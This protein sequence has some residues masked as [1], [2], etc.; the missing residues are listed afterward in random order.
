SVDAIAEFK[1]ITGI[2]P[3]EYGR[4]GGAIISVVTKSGSNQLHGNLFEFLRNN[5]FDA[6]NFFASNS[7]HLV[8]NQFGGSLG[9]P[10]A[11][12]GLYNGKNRTFFFA[13]VDLLRDREAGAPPILQVPTQQM[14]S[15]VFPSTIL[16][17][18]TGLPFANN[19]IPSGR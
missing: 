3:A 19:T 12:P 17:P 11:F 1:V 4:G 2:A 13:N 15:G 9:G 16:D 14:R 10:V 5:A 8:R 6:N 7:S 18:N